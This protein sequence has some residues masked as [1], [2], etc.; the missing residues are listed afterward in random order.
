[1]VKASAQ[2]TGKALKEREKKVTH[3]KA[4]EASRR[5]GNTCGRGHSRSFLRKVSSVASD[6]QS[7]GYKKTIAAQRAAL[8]EMKQH[9]H[10]LSSNTSNGLIPEVYVSNLVQTA[11]SRCLN[12][13]SDYDWVSKQLL[14]SSQQA[15]E[16]CSNDVHGRVQQAELSAYFTNH[17]FTSLAHI[18]G[19]FTA[20]QYNRDNNLQSQIQWRRKT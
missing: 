11:I 10:Y 4:L 20:Y 5:N 1:R 3:L 14:R 8:A 15:N 19:Y 17:W 16:I 6:C 13:Q 7:A 18:P 9:L 12:M 2:P